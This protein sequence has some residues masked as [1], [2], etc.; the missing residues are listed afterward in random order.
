V[1]MTM[2]KTKKLGSLGKTIMVGTRY[3]KIRSRADKGCCN[4]WKIDEKWICVCM[5]MD[6]RKH[7]DD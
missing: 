5:L 6:N 1:C 3:E 2:D 4:A 7:I